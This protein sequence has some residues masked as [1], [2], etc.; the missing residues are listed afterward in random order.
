MNYASLEKPVPRIVIATAAEGQPGTLA[1]SRFEFP[2]E[3]QKI[4]E[5]K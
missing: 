4:S 5:E 1:V 2:G 3:A